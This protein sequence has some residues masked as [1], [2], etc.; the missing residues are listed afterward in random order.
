[1]IINF[2]AME[3]ILTIL[4]VVGGILYKIYENYKEEMEKSRKRMQ[5]RMKQ[6]QPPAPTPQPQ[7]MKS[8]RKQQETKPIVLPVERKRDDIPPIPVYQPEA[9]EIDEVELAHQQRLARQMKQRQAQQ[10]Q[11]QALAL[12]E[13]HSNIQGEFDLRRAII[14]Q[15]ILERPYKD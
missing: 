1:K 6:M 5:E 13:E 3:T 14:Q 15:A 4:L 9:R 7:S 10:Q 2:K 12:V 8:A 11:Q